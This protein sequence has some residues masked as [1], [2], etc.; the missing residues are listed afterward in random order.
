MSKRGRKIACWVAGGL[1]VVAAIFVV[2]W[3][4]L[5]PAADWLARHD[6]SHATGTSLATARNN[7]QGNLLALA[8]G[9]AGFGALIF[10]ARTFILQRRTL[11]LTQQDQQDTHRLTE[12]GQVTDRYIKAIEQ[13]GS[14]KLDVRV[15]AIY[16]LERIARD[17]AADHPTVIEVLAMFIREHS[18]EQ[19]P[20]PDV[21]ASPPR[22]P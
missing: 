20:E 6:A 11:E 16:A 9:L 8:A 10:T 1:A 12:Q 22:E 7:A 15:G 21:R 17:S 13:L 4:L 19:W 3:A 18:R 5:V 14:D 2:G